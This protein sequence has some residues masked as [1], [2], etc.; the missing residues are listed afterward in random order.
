METQCITGAVPAAMLSTTLADTRA[1]LADHYR[2]ASAELEARKAELQSLRTDL[3]EQHERLRRQ[4]AEVEAWT[5]ERLEELRRR[6][7]AIASRQ[8]ELDELRS[9]Q[10]REHAGW[11]EQRERWEHQRRHFMIDQQASGLRAPHL[12]GLAE[13]RETADASSR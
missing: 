1:R 13:A 12:T 6:E 7:S 2:L 4:T 5:A 3:A 11:R 8:V 10:H 9:Q